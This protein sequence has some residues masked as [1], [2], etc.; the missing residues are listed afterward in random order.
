M[1]IQGVTGVFPFT[2]TED[3]VVTFR[4]L[5]I[6]LNHLR[7]EVM[8][9][10]A[11]K[12]A[13]PYSLSLASCSRVDWIWHACRGLLFLSGQ[14]E[15]SFFGGCCKSLAADIATCSKL[16]AICTHSMGHIGI[17]ISTVQRSSHNNPR[18]SF[19][20]GLTALLCSG[21]N[22]WLLGISSFHRHCQRGAGSTV[23]TD[24]RTSPV[25]APSNACVSSFY[26]ASC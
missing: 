12:T 6:Q 20:S 2:V 13:L 10:H 25:A 9:T 4:D 19:Y 17:S 15:R 7:G 11:D 23:T 8:N 21:F 18:L 22:S 26:D 5:L 3:M 14:V 24:G 1:S 16:L